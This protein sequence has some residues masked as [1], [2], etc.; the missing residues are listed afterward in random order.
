MLDR[1]P[2]AART[3]EVSRIS[4]GARVSVTLAP[5][6]EREARRLE[7]LAQSR[8]RRESHPPRRPTA[9]EYFRVSKALIPVVSTSIAARR[10]APWRARAWHPGPG[11]ASATGRIQTSTFK[12]KELR[13]ATPA[14]SLAVSVSK[15]RTRLSGSAQLDTRSPAPMGVSS[16]TCVQLP[17]RLTPV[18]ELVSR[19]WSPGLFAIGD[20]R[21]GFLVS[22]LARR[23]HRRIPAE[24]GNRRRRLST[25]AGVLRRSHPSRV[26]RADHMH[27]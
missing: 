23:R 26:R 10:R 4:E 18:P 2:E 15:S 17:S 20:P 14:R 13:E 19:S 16:N 7:E 24:R 6:S 22:V 3:S 1:I 5:T 9:A 25:F 21:H 8:D 27:R 12:L 11:A